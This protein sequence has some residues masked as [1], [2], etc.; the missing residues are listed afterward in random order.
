MLKKKQS[1]PLEDEPEALEAH[2]E[3]L[4]KRFER[5]KTMYESFF[6]GMEKQMP[7][8]QR[9]EMNRLITLTQQ[10]NIGKATLR[11]RFQSLLQ[12]WITYTAQWNRIQREIEQGTYQRDLQKVQRHLAEVG[13]KLTDA[14]AIAMGIPAV[15]V[16]QFVARQNRLVE[17]REAK[18]AAT[19]A[20][21]PAAKP[22]APIPGV[23][24]PQ[25]KLF[26]DE[27]N[28]ARAQVG[29]TRPAK[30]L[31]E[32]AERLRPQI[33]KVLAEAK[34]GRAKLQVTVQDGKVKVLASPD[35]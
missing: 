13:G 8:V 20:P 2:L 14:Q 3:Q 1:N 21:A 6:S 7:L 33:E 28:R 15:R 11:F 32:L 4:E 30:P 27:Y 5:L 17:E 35:E 22:P 24:L 16:K 18:G 23:T 31:E 12:R 26:Y 10:L 34:A 25:L 29:D 19:A 9:R